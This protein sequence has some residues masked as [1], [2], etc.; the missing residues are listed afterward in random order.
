[1][2]IFKRL[3]SKRKKEQTEKEIKYQELFKK[4]RDLL[5]KKL[6]I[7]PSDIQLSSRLVEDLNIDSLNSIELIMAFEETFNIDIPD[8]DAEKALTV[9]EIVDYIEKKTL[10]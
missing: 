9:K 4:V 2:G 7:H 1:M 6:E 5:A 10:K 3:L 8:E